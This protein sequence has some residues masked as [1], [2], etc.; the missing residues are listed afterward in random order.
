MHGAE[1]KPTPNWPTHKGT[2]DFWEELGRAVATFA[3]L[4]FAMRRTFIALTWSQRCASETEALA[5]LPDAEKQ[6]VASVT[7]TFHW[8]TKKIEG[9][10]D[11]DSRVSLEGGQ[12]IVNSLR[13]IGNYRN[14][15]CHG[16]WIRFG[17]DG[18][19]Q[20]LYVRKTGKREY[21]PYRQSFSSA[22]IRDIRNHSTE[23]AR[24]LLDI[25]MS[26]GFE[27]TSRTSLEEPA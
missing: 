10:F 16:A 7:D 21:E 2:S 8:L 27:F 15:L 3:W 9:V 5:I 4:E 1:A 13:E 14:A 19:G 26:T 6:S 24:R 23:V 22:Q 20:L 25:E 17:E 18:S 12:W 11:V